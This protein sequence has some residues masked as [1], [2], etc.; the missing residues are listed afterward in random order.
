LELLADSPDTV[1][2]R[3][4]NADRHTCNWV[5]DARGPGA[6]CR[7]CELTRTEPPADDPASGEPLA[8]AETAKRRLIFQLDGLGLPI[9][10]RQDDPDTG[11]AF[12]LLSS[13]DEP[14]TTGHRDGVIAIDLAESDDVHREG[15]RQ[16]MG[17]AYRTMLGHM[18]HEIGHYYWMVFARDDSRLTRI[19]RRF[20]DDTVDYGDSLEQHYGG[21]PPPG[22]EQSFVSAYATTHPWEDFAETFAHYLHIR[23]TL[24]TAAAYGM[25]ITGPTEAQGTVQAESLMSVPDDDVDLDR[26]PFE[27]I[28]AEWL[29][30]TYALNELNRAMGK[31]PLYPFVLTPKVV[32]KLSLV[33]RMVVQVAREQEVAA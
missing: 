30:L 3:C 10:G 6:L 9:V 25:I 19:R 7:S 28:L 2:R 22:W 33:H 20:G 12:D 11:L 8:V 1:F 24:E 27:T 23:G 26:E 21:G 29:P 17:E 32:E 18:R 5:L 16:A 14:V 15:V 31:R 13:R 4:A